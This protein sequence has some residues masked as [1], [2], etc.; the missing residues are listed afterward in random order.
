MGLHEVPETWLELSEYRRS[1]YLQ[2]DNG[3]GVYYWLLI[4]M[5]YEVKTNGLS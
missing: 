3:S 1:F 4:G 2:F 5:I